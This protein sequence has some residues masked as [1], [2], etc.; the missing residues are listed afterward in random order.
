MTPNELAQ[1][2]IVLC[3][4]NKSNVDTKTSQMCMDYYVNCVVDSQGGIHK[5]KLEQCK[6]AWEKEHAK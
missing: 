2:I 1:V 5:E 6:A 3:H 4:L